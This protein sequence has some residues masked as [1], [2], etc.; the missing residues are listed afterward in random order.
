M[1][2]E[3]RERLAATL[4]LEGTKGFRWEEASSVIREVFLYKA[5]LIMPLITAHTERAVAAALEQILKH[6]YLPPFGPHKQDA[7][8]AACDWVSRE[9]TTDLWEQWVAHIP[10][11][12]P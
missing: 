6:K 1:S 7:N 2:D 8:C 10:P 11:E 12:K 9:N 3:L 5:D 4:C